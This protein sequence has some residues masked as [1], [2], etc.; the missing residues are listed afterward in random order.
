M[1]FYIFP[2]ILFIFSKII[3]F[4]SSLMETRFP[5]SKSNF[6]EMSPFSVSRK[7]YVFMLVF[8]CFYLQARKT[9]GISR[10][11]VTSSHIQTTMWF[12]FWLACLLGLSYLNAR[13]TIVRQKWVNWYGNWW[14]SEHS[15]VL[16]QRC[17][18]RKGYSLVFKTF[19]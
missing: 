6:R 9:K 13:V 16:W 15:E 5:F 12:L 8:K 18:D 14:M 17:G 7:T 1:F 4:F 10:S 19:L 11:A 2:R 3:S